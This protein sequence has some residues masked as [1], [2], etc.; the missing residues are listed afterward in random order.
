MVRDCS[1]RGDGAGFAHL[2]CIVKYAEQKCK[3]TANT[4]G[5]LPM[6]RFSEPW[7]DCPNCKQPFKNQLS[8]DLSSAFVS[9]AEATFGYPGNNPMDKIKVMTALRSRIAK[10]ADVKRDNMFR[11]AGPT[12][13]WSQNNVDSN[14]NRAQTTECKMLFAK[15][16]LVVDQM[17]KD[18]KMDGWIHMPRTS[19]KYRLYKCYDV[20][21]R[22]EDTMTLGTLQVMTSQKKVPIFLSNATRKLGSSIIYLASKT[23]PKQ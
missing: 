12:T 18:L 17:K 13:R 16:L 19:D 5:E 22:H 4:G 20:N 9:F 10:Y 7:D 21:T 1:C 6:H 3:Q 23:R 14:R 15:L 11:E 8:L 2:S